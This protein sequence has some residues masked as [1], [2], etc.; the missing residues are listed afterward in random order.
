MDRNFIRLAGAQIP[1]TLN[2]G[3]NINSIKSAIDWAKENS[4]DYIATPEAS[5]SGYQE[6]FNTPELMDALAT[7]E[8]YAKVSKVGLLL[9]TLW[10]EKLFDGT[11]ELQNQLRVYNKDGKLHNY[12][13]KK[14]LCPLDNKIGITFNAEIRVAFLQTDLDNIVV[15]IAGVLCND[16]YG[17]EGFAPV[18]QTLA[19]YNY[20]IYIHATNA[21]RNI[22]PQY[23]SVFKEHH[24]ATLRLVSY[25]SKKTAILTV[26]NCYNINGEPSKSGT[27]STSGVLYKGD[28]LTTAPDEDTQYFYHDFQLDEFGIDQSDPENNLV[29]DTNAS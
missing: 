28:W 15:P 23:D 16:L 8:E 10:E 11:L 3:K 17:K 26:D 14:I 1:V 21:E 7:V 27:S 19:K 2:V 18:M 13:S 5:L 9:G 4:V 6:N 20:K 24:N 25:L 29:G 12:F 22:D